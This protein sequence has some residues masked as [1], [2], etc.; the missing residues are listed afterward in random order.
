MTLTAKSLNKISV[1][2]VIL[3]TIIIVEE[4]HAKDLILYAVQLIAMEDA[5]AATPLMNLSVRNAVTPSIETPTATLMTHHKIV[6]NAQFDISR[7]PILAINAPLLIF[8]VDLTVKLMEN[9]R[10]AIKDI[11]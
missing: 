1:R 8:Y 6:W 11:V 4:V 5:Q 10:N 2:N 7:I 3:V 9:A